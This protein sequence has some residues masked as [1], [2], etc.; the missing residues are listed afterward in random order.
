MDRIRKPPPAN[1]K[2]Y[3]KK[4]S[5]HNRQMLVAL[6]TVVFVVIFIL[7][8]TYMTAILLNGRSLTQCLTEQPQSSSNAQIECAVQEFFL[9]YDVTV[10]IWSLCLALT[11]AAAPR[12]VLAL[13]GGGDKSKDLASLVRLSSTLYAGVPVAWAVAATRCN[14][15]ALLTGVNFAWGVACAM[16]GGLLLLH[17]K[18]RLYSVCCIL[19]GTM[20]ASRNAV[21]F[22][23]GDT[24]GLSTTLESVAS[25]LQ[26]VADTASSIHGAAVDS[27]ALTA[28]A[29]LADSTSEDTM[30]TALQTGRQL[31]SVASGLL[32][33]GMLAVDMA[34]DASTS[35]ASGSAMGTGATL[36]DVVDDGVTNALPLVDSGISTIDI[37]TDAAPRA[38]D[39]ASATLLVADA[40]SDPS[41]RSS[42]TA[43]AGAIGTTAENAVDAGVS[44]GIQG[45]SIGTLAAD[46]ASNPG[47][48]S[49]L[50][51]AGA[52]APP[53]LIDAAIES[54]DTA[55]PAANDAIAAVDKVADPDME[56]RTKIPAAFGLA[57]SET[58]NTASGKSWTNAQ[59]AELK[60]S[61]GTRA[62]VYKDDTMSHVQD[63]F[64]TRYRDPHSNSVFTVMNN[65]VKTFGGI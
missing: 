16:Q 35:R 46:V 62:A 9:Q 58:L 57:A 37:A 18:V 8:A 50:A 60:T 64:L 12:R 32:S 36:A 44:T 3:R 52:T 51:T 23:D 33:Q 41:T 45:S 38:T 65:M 48:Y 11:C 27:G 43:G 19:I 61:L 59:T 15:L 6:W 56:K 47:S 17:S 26:N 14:S 34:T 10:P 5:G 31:V 55:T 28:V 20:V 2:L 40:V 22:Q 1:S 24:P 13:L 42:V 29:D 53:L 39:A 4:N 54:V 7:E 49:A 25:S 21:H 30:A 63:L